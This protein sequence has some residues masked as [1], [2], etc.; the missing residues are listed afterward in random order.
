M[1]KNIK[2]DL[3]NLID[4]IDQGKYSNIQLNYYFTKN[5]Y[6][7][8]EKAFLTNMVNVIIKN[9]LLIDYVLDKSSKN[10]QKRKIKQLLRISL[11]QII[12]LENEPAGVVYEAVEIA[13]SINK[14]QSGF[15]NA[16][17]QYI[18]KNYKEIIDNIPEAIKESVL[19]S[20]PQWLVNK[21]KIDFP[22]EYLDIM[23]SYKEKSHLSVRI[24]ENLISKNEFEKLL[25]DIK[26]KIL[27]KV[28]NVYYI[29]NANI[30]NTD[31]F[32]KGKII[33]QDASSY[34]AALNIDVNNDDLILDACSAPGGKSLAILQEHSKI[35]FKLISTDIHNHK[36]DKM[37]DLKKK[38]SYNEWNIIK[39][40]AKKIEELDM[41]FDAILLDVPC[42]GLG[43]IRQKPEKI[44]EIS[45]SDIKNIKKLQ[46]EIFDSAYNSLKSGG[47]IVYSTCTITPNENT[48]NVEFF[49]NKYS[50]LEILEIN[51][52]ENVKIKKDEFGGIYITHKN[53]Y[54]DGFYIAKF[55]KK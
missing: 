2:I 32:K 29:S 20:Y 13:K 52:P 36:I 55:K 51:I 24:A 47:T 22:N 9:K 33:V 23:K 37:L 28:E 53:M 35:Q 17:L 12:I 43:V 49:L 11:A 4:E 48:N 10:I 14:F 7:Q 16:T 1:I 3:I 50:D 26:S 40:D 42:S 38:Y 21:F 45:N 34:I 54:M 15:V 41:K 25:E 8:K 27:F 39:N 44:Y 19:Y 30:L 6:T 5:Q 18:V 46:K 31:E